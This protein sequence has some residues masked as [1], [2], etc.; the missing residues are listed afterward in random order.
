MTAIDIV[1]L[2]IIALGL[3]DGLR[4]GFVRQLAA[5]VGVIAGLFVARSLYI[6]V[7]KQAVPILGTSNQITE[8]LAF[9]LIWGAV[10]VVFSSIASLLSR[11]LKTIH[12][13]W[14]DSWLGGALGA[15]KYICIL[16]IVAYGIDHFNLEYDFISDTKK[17]E[18]KFY[19]PIKEVSSLYVPLV[20]DV[21]KQLTK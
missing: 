13:G 17:H 20:K 14:L 10:P 19:Y 11:L 2:V 6:Y 3:I 9:I 12:L 16:S 7:A 21:T 5:T 1:I 4:K 8:L 18:S 15:L